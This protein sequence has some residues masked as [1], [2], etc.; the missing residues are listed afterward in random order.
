MGLQLQSKI[1]KLRGYDQ[2][3]DDQVK[4]LGVQK[5]C[6][7]TTKKSQL[8][9]WNDTDTNSMC[10]TLEKNISNLNSNDLCAEI[11]D[12]IFNQYHNT[13]NDIVSKLVQY[14]GQVID[15]R[16]QKQMK[17]QA[18]L[19]EEEEGESVK[20]SLDKD[21]IVGAPKEAS[22]NTTTPKTDSPS[23]SIPQIQTNTTT[24]KNVPAPKT[25]TSSAQAN[26]TVDASVDSILKL[27]NETCVFF[28]EFQD[29]DANLKKACVNNSLEESQNKIHD[30]LVNLNGEYQNCWS[31]ANCLNK[32]D[33]D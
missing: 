26:S 9:L 24:Q 30:Q 25:G 1:D 19:E 3:K 2:C 14:T 22:S 32:M 31:N 27:T 15:K 29:T 16:K 21:I 28:G 33:A 23:L 8:T 5:F 7:S 20:V 17:M 12:G 18:L 6:V 4:M 13:Q 10:N 11:N